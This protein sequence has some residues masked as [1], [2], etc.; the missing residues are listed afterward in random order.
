M[1]GISINPRDRK[2]L[3]NVQFLVLYSVNYVEIYSMK[4][5]REV[6]KVISVW[7]TL[8]MFLIWRSHILNKLQHKTHDICF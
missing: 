8:I 5:F 4:V 1:Y 2:L 6:A 3:Q 7:F